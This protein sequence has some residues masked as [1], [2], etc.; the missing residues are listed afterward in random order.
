MIVSRIDPGYYCEGKI[1]SDGGHKFIECSKPA[2]FQFSDGGED[3]WFCPR[4]A[5]RAHPQMMSA[6]AAEEEVRRQWLVHAT[7]TR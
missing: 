3:H 6:L 1:R 4:C 5:R 7:G 2:P